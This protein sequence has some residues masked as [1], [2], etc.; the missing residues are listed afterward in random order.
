MLRKKKLSILINKV[1]RVN[2]DNHKVKVKIRWKKKMYF[3]F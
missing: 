3:F 2:D 1:F